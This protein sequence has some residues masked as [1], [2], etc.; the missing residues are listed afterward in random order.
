ES[1]WIQIVK[2]TDLTPLPVDARSVLEC[3]APPRRFRSRQPRPQPRFE[4]APKPRTPHPSALRPAPP[5]VTQPRCGRGEC[6][7]I[8]FLAYRLR[9]APGLWGGIP[10]ALGF[11]K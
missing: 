1:P 9:R 2:S 7:L 11:G 5:Q 6:L 3:A 10:L 8:R 4:D